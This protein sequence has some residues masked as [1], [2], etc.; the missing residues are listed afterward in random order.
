MVKANDA[1]GLSPLHETANATVK[2]Q[3]ASVNGIL[4]LVITVT[5]AHAR[6]ILFY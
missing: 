6:C 4:H 1:D 5:L 2:Q 3:K